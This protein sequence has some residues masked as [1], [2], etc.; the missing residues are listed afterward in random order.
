[1]SC[2]A[3]PRMCTAR[4]TLLTG[5]FGT[6][7]AILGAGTSNCQ[8]IQATV[9]PSSKGKDRS[10]PAG[11]GSGRANCE[12]A[13]TRKK[14]PFICVTP[15]LGISTKAVER[16]LD[17][18]RERSTT[19]VAPEFHLRL[20]IVRRERDIG[21]ALIG[22]MAGVDGKVGAPP[23]LLVCSALP[24]GLPPSHGSRLSISMRRSSP[25]GKREE[26]HE[27]EAYQ[28]HRQATAEHFWHAVTLWFHALLAS[29]A[30]THI[31]PEDTPATSDSASRNSA[32]W[33]CR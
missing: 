2:S 33:S 25:D 15:R 30:F 10:N 16:A 22:G 29:D 24:S 18:S 17:G 3:A 13:A 11:L 8:P 12:P 31:Y 9:K 21:D 6:F 14:N 7:S 26:E 23:D 27:R 1:M 28:D 5:A 32:C 19:K 4:T 20:R